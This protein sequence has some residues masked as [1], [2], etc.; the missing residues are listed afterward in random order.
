MTSTFAPIDPSLIDQPSPEIAQTLD[1]N[2]GYTPRL[3]AADTPDALKDC[4][5][6]ASRDFPQSFYIDPKDRKDKANEN[7]KNHTWG[8]NYLDRFTNQNPTHEC[9]SHS[10]RANFE[11]ARNLQLGI[12]YPDGPKKGFRYEQSQKGSVWV[13]PLSIYA[14]ANPSKWGGAGV[15]QILNIA[16]KRGFLPEKTQPYDYKFKHDLVGTT[17]TG[18][19]NQSSGNWVSVSN[20]PSGWQETAATLMPLEVVVMDDW[21]QAFCMILQGRIVSVGRSGHAIPY[22]HWNEASQAVG[23]VDSYDVIRWDSLRTARQAVSY[24]C[25]SII[26]VTTPD[27]WMNPAGTLAA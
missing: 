10:G 1:E 8:L 19:L 18:G 27:D 4:C 22:S 9:T 20:F 16:C 24:G 3:Q 6:D 23:Y 12:R 2:A 7:D 14:E 15:V 21:E 17:G 5:G 25:F 26:S 11:G 13:S